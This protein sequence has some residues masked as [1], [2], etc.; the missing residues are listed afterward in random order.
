MRVRLPSAQTASLTVEHQ[1][2]PDF[3]SNQKPRQGRLR[4][5]KLPLRAAY[6]GFEV[7]PLAIIF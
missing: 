5:D 4:K 2:K 6:V 3:F 1:N 7:Q